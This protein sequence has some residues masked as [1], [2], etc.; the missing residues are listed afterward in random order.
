MFMTVD[1]RCTYLQTV[2][3]RYTIY[4]EVNNLLPAVVTKVIGSH[5]I[6]EEINN[7]D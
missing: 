4:I 5:F 2:D 6:R 3:N 1:N 7:E